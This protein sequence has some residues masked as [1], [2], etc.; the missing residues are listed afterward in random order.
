MAARLSRYDHADIITSHVS[1]ESIESLSRRLRISQY[2]IRM[3]LAPAGLVEVSHGV[4]SAQ[5]AA[6][7]K[8]YESGVSAQAV[9]RQFG[10]A[11]S[12]ARLIFAR[13]GLRR[14]GVRTTTVGHRTQAF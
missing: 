2:S 14:V 4:S 7:C 6:A 12:T 8:L 11:E 3:V 9:A 13:E 5:L 1:G 10:V